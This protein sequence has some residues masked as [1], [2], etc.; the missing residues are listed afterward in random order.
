MKAL[1]FAI[2]MTLVF[3]S[4][5]FGQTYCGLTEAEARTPNSQSWN[6]LKYQFDVDGQP[7]HWKMLLLKPTHHAP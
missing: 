5:S 2:T 4:I 7:R 3:T 1:A 6:I